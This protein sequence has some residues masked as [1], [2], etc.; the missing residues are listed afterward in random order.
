MN[1]MSLPTPR[2]RG[3]IHWKWEQK[4]HWNEK[5]FLKIWILG[6]ASNKVFNKEQNAELNSVSLVE[7][8]R[9]QTKDREE[10][11][12][13]ESQSTKLRIACIQNNTQTKD[14]YFSRTY[15]PCTQGPRSSR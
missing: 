14:H 15:I 11:T 13:V 1:V 3:K 4:K 2:A 12:Q 9:W 10:R 6:K 5:F 7:L 8:R